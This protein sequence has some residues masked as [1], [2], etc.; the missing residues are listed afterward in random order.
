MYLLGAKLLATYP[1][2]PLW[3]SHGVG[4]AMFSYNGQ[5]FWGFNADYD[6]L[7]DLPNFVAAMADAFTEMQKA[8]ENPP[9]PPTTEK[10]AAKRRPPMGTR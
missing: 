7:E 3:E 2:V 1:L 9:E 5:V 10:G 4:L 8:A 6:L